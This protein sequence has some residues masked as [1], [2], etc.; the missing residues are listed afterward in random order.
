MEIQKKLNQITKDLERV[1][2]KVQLLTDSINKGASKKAKIPGSVSRNRNKSG[3]ATVL[4]IIRKSRKGVDALTLIKKTGFKDT[5]IRNILF[6]GL[7]NKRIQRVSRGI[8]RIS[9]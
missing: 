7:K 4:D 8:Y 2:K 5:K 6:Q 3:T 1:T 9:K